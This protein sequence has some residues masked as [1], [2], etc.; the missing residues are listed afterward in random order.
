MAG[1]SFVVGR[2][3]GLV[4]LVRVGREVAPRGRPKKER[5]SELPVDCWGYVDCWW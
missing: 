1:G 2:E 5:S 4:G 3:R